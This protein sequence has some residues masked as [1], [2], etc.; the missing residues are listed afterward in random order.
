[1]GIEMIAFCRVH[2][3]IKSLGLPM[4]QC[5]TAE[6]LRQCKFAHSCYQ[7][8]LDEMKRESEETD[9]ERRR[10]AVKEEL[11]LTEKKKKLDSTVTDL[12]READHLALDAEKQNK[13]SMLVKSDALKI[14][15]KGKKGSNGKL[16]SK[17][18]KT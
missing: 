6:M 10:K 3:G 11:E 7:F 16:R 5:V 1:M 2:D 9:R 14:K 17:R 8:H 18:L 4:E 12:E 13:M 15:G